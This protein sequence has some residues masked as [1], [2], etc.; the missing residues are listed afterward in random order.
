MDTDS[1]PN[2]KTRKARDRQQDRFQNAKLV[3]NMVN[4][5]AGEH[6]YQY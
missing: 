2:R 6:E 4:P 5:D 1:H 3:K